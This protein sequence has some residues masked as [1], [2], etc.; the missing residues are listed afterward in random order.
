MKF[1]K[2]TPRTVCSSAVAAILQPCVKNNCMK[3]K[4]WQPAFTQIYARSCRSAYAHSYTTEYVH[5]TWHRTQTVYSR[6]DLC[7]NTCLRNMSLRSNNL[8]LWYHMINAMNIC[9]AC[10][11]KLLPFDCW[12]ALGYK[13]SKWLVIAAVLIMTLATEAIKCKTAF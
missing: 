11:F 8:E 12:Q 9:M 4:M 7:H 10:I 5:H 1:V 13:W 6:G 2:I 3:E